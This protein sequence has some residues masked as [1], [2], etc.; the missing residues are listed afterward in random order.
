[1]S[2]EQFALPT[3]LPKT[4]VVGIRNIYDFPDALLEL[5]DTFKRSLNIPV[6]KFLLFKQILSLGLGSI[7]VS[8]SAC[9]AE[10]LGS[11]PSRAVVF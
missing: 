11:I 10:D 2:E 9:H 3:F 7:M 6:Y 1:M 4:A 5:Q 8:I